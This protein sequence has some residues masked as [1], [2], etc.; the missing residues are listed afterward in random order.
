MVPLRKVMHLTAKNLLLNLIYY[1]VT[2]VAAPAV[3]LRLDARWGLS[4]PISGGILKTTSTLL[5]AA[6]AAL[7]LWCIVLFQRLGRGTPSPAIPPERLVTAGPYRLVRNPMNLGELSVFVGL[8]GWFASPT[9]LLYTA[10][11]AVAFH[12]FVVYFEEPAHA[13]RFGESY[14]RYQMCTGRWL[15]RFRTHRS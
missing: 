6:G 11:G 2:L 8:S 7:Q 4:L 14:T 5:A 13:R 9:L 3:C 15:P 1:A 12:I 10:V